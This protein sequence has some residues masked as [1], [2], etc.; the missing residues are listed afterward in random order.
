VVFIQLKL[1]DL[2]YPTA[3]DGKFGPQTAAV[4]RKF[5]SRRGFVVD[6]EVGL[7]TWKGLFGLGET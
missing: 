2:G 6:G 4:V 1:R 7:Q 5:Q 3:I